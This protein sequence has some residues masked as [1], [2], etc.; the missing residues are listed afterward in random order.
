MEPVAASE[1]ARCFCGK[2]GHA[3]KA[4]HYPTKFLKPYTGVSAPLRSGGFRRFF[5][6]LRQERISADQRVERAH[7]GVSEYLLEHGY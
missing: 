5:K 4:D 3:L 7:G 2:V 6:T 1:T